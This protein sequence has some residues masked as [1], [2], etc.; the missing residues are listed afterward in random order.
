VIISNIN[1]YKSG[2][3]VGDFEPSIYKNKD[4]EI[5]VHKHKKGDP[6]FPHYHKITNELNL[7]L[8][9][10]IEVSNNIFN[11][12]DIWIYEQNE[13]SDV[14]FITDVE[15]LIVRWPSIPSD[16]YFI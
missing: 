2:W 4:F 13:I 8:N 3:I 7:V 5:A 14:V 15:L 9:G 16:K 11:K 1:N 12:G 6:T 10:T